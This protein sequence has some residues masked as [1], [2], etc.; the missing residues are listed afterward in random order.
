MCRL[1]EGTMSV[2]Q[3]LAARRPAAIGF[4]CA[5]AWLGV[6]CGDAST[7]PINSGLGTLPG[8]AGWGATAA[9]APS[10]AG[11]ISSIGTGGTGGQATTGLNP[12]IT[13]PGEGV[14]GAGLAAAG[15][16]LA[17][18]GSAAGI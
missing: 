3:F 5:V 10:S 17:G 16:G 4:S 8:N 7:N 12:G 2:R 11:A 9:G 13:K 15:S 1:L 14:A 6:G 18:S